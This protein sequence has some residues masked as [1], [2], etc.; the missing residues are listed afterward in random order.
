MIKRVLVGSILLA[1]AS[2]GA[3]CE[4]VSY[5][6]TMLDWLTAAGISRA[7]LNIN[8]NLL[9]TA[10]D[11]C[12]DSVSAY[13]P[14]GGVFAGTALRSNTDLRLTLDN[15][16][17]GTGLRLAITHNG[18]SDTIAKFTDDSTFK[19]WR[20]ILALDTV[21][22]EDGF[23]AGATAATNV[24]WTRASADMW[25][26]PDSLTVTGK[27]KV[28]GNVNIN[29]ATDASGWRLNV[30]DGGIA[31]TN[32][33]TIASFG[34]GTPSEVAAGNTEYIQLRHASSL[35]ELRVTRSNSGTFRDFVLSTSDAE[36]YRV[37]AAGAHTITGAASFTSTAAVTGK[38][39]S[40]DSVYAE[41]GIRVG[42]VGASNVNW[43]R[44]AANMWSTP[45]SV[46]ILGELNVGDSVLGASARFTGTVAADSIISDKFYTEGTF[47]GTL[48]G[49]TTSPTVTIYYVR[50]GKHVTLTIPSTIT[51]TSN[52]TAATITG[53]PA[54]LR[55]ARSQ[56]MAYDGVWNNS[57]T[58][59]GSIG[60]NI[61]AG[62]DRL[63]LWYHSAAGTAS[64]NSFTSSGLKG[65]DPGTIS[66]ILN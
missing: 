39:G 40:A 59:M 43:N 23:R 9:K 65:L 7:N 58:Y 8:P 17:N 37:T 61:T 3:L 60:I 32:G 41:D 45:D 63:E 13:V 34:V 46:T 11:N 4:R 36:R 62:F 28:T 53:L 64:T 5:Y 57:S 29:G 33:N 66:Y 21:A 47:T 52:T 26:T 50:V 6:G 14:G 15:D 12:A 10:Y 2:F 31:T 55:P 1:Q 18:A 22:A 44:S 19:V 30:S 24:L 54:A 48:T 51:A 25:S 35:G 38:L 49:C 20:N 16:A 56:F 27:L 42:S